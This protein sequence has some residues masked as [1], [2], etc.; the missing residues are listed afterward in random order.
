MQPILYQFFSFFFLTSC[1]DFRSDPLL[2]F[3]FFLRAVS[4]PSEAERKEARVARAAMH[5]TGAL[6]SRQ[7]AQ[8][9]RDGVGVGARGGPRRDGA[10]VGARG[11][12]RCGSMMA[13]AL[14]LAAFQASVVMGG[15]F[16]ETAAARFLGSSPLAGGGR[17]GCCAY[18]SF[19][20][21]LLPFLLLP[22]AF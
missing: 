4:S 15:R 2:L 8:R 17:R 20:T 22:P 3:L 19:F 10:G 11:G 9:R 5:D 1:E 7:R 21:H 6:R 16:E 12:R 14:T 13:A 18:C